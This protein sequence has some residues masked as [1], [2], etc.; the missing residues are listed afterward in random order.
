MGSGPAAADPAAA[1]SAM[2][3]LEACLA[4]SDSLVMSPFP[5][6]AMALLPIR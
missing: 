3:L 5:K 6:S 2:V 1:S 4:F